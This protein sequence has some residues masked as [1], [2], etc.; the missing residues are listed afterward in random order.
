ML[1]DDDI[2]ASARRY[3][4]GALERLLAAACPTVNRMARG[5]SG[6]QDVGRGIARFVM[7]RAVGRVPRFLDADAAQRWFCHHTV[8]TARRAAQ[9]QPSPRDDVLVV[10]ERD[11]AY[12][13]FVRALR[14]LPLQQREAFILH[15]GELM[16]LRQLA[17]AMDCSMRAAELHLRAA[18]QALAPIAAD[19]DAMVRRMRGAYAQLAGDED[20][21]LPT[22]RSLVRRSLLARR[23]SRL[24]KL[25]AALLML[26][27]VAYA[28]WR[29]HGLV[30]WPPAGG[31]P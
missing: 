7:T 19:Y 1:V 24:V 30:P 5:L 25:I 20:E 3:D 13:A 27:A 26:A 31:Q 2:V 18:E 29:F 14:S 8:L 15:H 21:L 11:P 10:G 22:V 23:I 12:L 6:R 17:I 16:D 9:H 28:A 4:R